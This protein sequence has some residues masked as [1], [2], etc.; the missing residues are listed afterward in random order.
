MY[1]LSQRTDAIIKKKRKKRNQP[2]LFTGGLMQFNRIEMTVEG[3][4]A[5]SFNLPSEARKKS[6]AKRGLTGRLH[7]K[8][9]LS[10][11]DFYIQHFIVITYS[12]I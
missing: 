12:E 7:A 3:A 4:E 5:D 8:E 6:R 9:D 10:K 1:H 11:P 2:R